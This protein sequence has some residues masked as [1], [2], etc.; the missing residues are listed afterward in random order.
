MFYKYR[1]LT[2]FEENGLWWYHDL[3]A[4]EE[5]DGMETVL[6]CIAT[7]FEA[8]AISVSPTGHE[9]LTVVMEYEQK[10]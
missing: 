5:R 8:R 3:N 4:E 1:V 7:K 10:G 9:M 2:F 6:N